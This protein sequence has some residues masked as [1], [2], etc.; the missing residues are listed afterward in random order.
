M[1]ITR[2]RLLYGQKFFQQ[3]IVTMIVED[4]YQKKM[5]ITRRRLLYGLKF[6][7]QQIVTMI[8]EDYYVN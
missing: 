3:Q 6:F 8:V 7:Q 4:Y 1:L 5:L 2:R